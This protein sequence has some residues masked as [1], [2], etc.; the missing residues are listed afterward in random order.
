MLRTYCPLRLRLFPDKDT[1]DNGRKR[2]DLCLPT[3]D[4]GRG[5]SAEKT[6]MIIDISTNSVGGGNVEYAFSRSS[7]HPPG[8]GTNLYCSGLLLAGVSEKGSE[9]GGRL[10]KTASVV[11]VTALLEWQTF[12]AR[13]LSVFADS[14]ESLRQAHAVA[15]AVKT[16]R[17]QNAPREMSKRPTTRLWS[18]RVSAHPGMPR[19][20]LPSS[21]AQG[22]ASSWCCPTLSAR[23]VHSSALLQLCL[24]R[25]NLN[26]FASSPVPLNG[27]WS[28][29]A[30]KRIAG[31]PEP[32][33]LTASITVHIPRSDSTLSA[34]ITAPAI[35]IARQ[36]EPQPH[37]TAAATVLHSPSFPHNQPIS[38]NTPT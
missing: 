12:S 22:N 20:P 10:S 36:R 17:M 33:S 11:R 5:V 2:R 14:G 18:V 4:Y 19:A 1:G 13:E 16:E 35:K 34:R 21:I 28:K 29:T 9:E 3:E 27:L 37:A 30:S 8:Q 23:L 32:G 38:P 24:I 15:T 31:P 26:P 7:L 25:H 6:H